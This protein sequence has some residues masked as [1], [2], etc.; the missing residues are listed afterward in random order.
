LQVAGLGDL[1]GTGKSEM[2]LRNTSTGDFWLYNYD[3][4]TNS[5]TGAL[6]GAVGLNWQAA[7]FAPVNGTGKVEMVL[8]DSSTGAFE[9]YSYSVGNN[10]LSGTALGA[11]GLDWQPGGFAVDPP[12]DDASIGQ[13]VQTMAGFGGSGAGMSNAV[14]LSADPSQQTFLTTP[15]QG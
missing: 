6:V 15:Q 4:N 11:V 9:A 1:R 3:V 13:L 7:G 2:V 12:T 14:P 8:R 10:A 5:L